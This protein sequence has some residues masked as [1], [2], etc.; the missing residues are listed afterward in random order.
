[1][2]DGY[3]QPEIIILANPQTLIEP[4]QRFKKLSRHHHGR[5][6]HQTTLQTAAKNVP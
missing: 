1:M 4:A 6:A 2:I 3:P 5:R